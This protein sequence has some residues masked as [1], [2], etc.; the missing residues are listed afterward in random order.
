[1]LD[2]RTKRRLSQKLENSHLKRLITG[3]LAS[4]LASKPDQIPA[5]EYC[6]GVA[7]EIV[8]ELRDTLCRASGQSSQTEIVLEEADQTPD[9]NGAVKKLSTGVE[10][11][12]LSGNL[13]MMRALGEAIAQRDTG[14]SSHNSRVTL[15]STLTA[16]VMELESE[17]VRT[18]MKGSFLHDIGKIGISDDII[19]KPGG[20]TDDERRTMNAHP[21]IG[22][23]IVRGVTWLEDAREVIRYHHE[24]FDGTGYPHKLVGKSIPL[25]ARIFAVVDVFDA[26]TSKRPYKPAYSYEKTMQI[27]FDRRGTHFD[28][29]IV[30][31]FAN[32]SRRLYDE[33]AWEPYH[34]L[35][36][37]LRVKV[38]DHFD[39]DSPLGA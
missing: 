7:E 3:E 34:V 21:E 27:I 10:Q 24:W 19:L 5:E 17:M 25:S 36:T 32:I 9:L 6:T 1:M 14:N 13:Q 11:A 20:L 35:D 22:A 39:L 29:W 37:Q 30:E 28:P 4:L 31:S 2:D 23:A 38:A 33:I 12:L 26:L 8:H 16:E 15:Y 18:L